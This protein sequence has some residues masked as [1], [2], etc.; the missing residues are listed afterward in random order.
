LL[1]LITMT[2]Q[3]KCALFHSAEYQS[4]NSVTN[5]RCVSNLETDNMQTVVFHG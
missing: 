4:V 3:L 2:F 1:L 5:S